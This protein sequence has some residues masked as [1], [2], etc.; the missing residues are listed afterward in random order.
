MDQD[1]AAEGRKIEG[2]PWICFWQLPLVMVLLVALSSCLSPNTHQAGSLFA[3]FSLDDQAR[4]VILPIVHSAKNTFGF[5]ASLLGYGWRLL[6]PC[7]LCL[8]RLLVSHLNYDVFRVKWS[9]N[10]LNING[11]SGRYLNPAV[12]GISKEPFWLFSVDKDWGTVLFSIWLTLGFLSLHLIDS[13]CFRHRQSLLIDK[14]A[15]G[16]KI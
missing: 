16:S 10:Y 3:S 7:V 15:K 5:L 13:V 9:V 2:P 11:I 14:I 6:Y 4:S 8:N 12:V 1:F